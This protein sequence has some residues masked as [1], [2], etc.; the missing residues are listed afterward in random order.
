[1]MTVHTFLGIATIIM[2]IASLTVFT[3]KMK[4]L[5]GA[6]TKARS[7]NRIDRVGKR[8]FSLIMHVFGHKR[9]LKMRLSG[10]IHLFIFSGFVVLFLDI[11]ETIVKVIIPSFS[12]WPFLGAI[13]DIWVLIILIGIMMAFYNRRVVKP[14]RF[15][16]SNESDATF[17]LALITIIVV[18]I[19]I[20]TS[21]YMLIAED[22]FSVRPESGH[23][24]GALLAQLWI[25]IGWDTPTI[26]SIGYAVGYIMDIGTI[27]LFLA[28]LPGSK[29][30]H[31]LTSVP[32]V[33]TRDLD[34][35]VGL[36]TGTLT[37]YEDAKKHAEQGM[38]IYSFSDL[39]WKDTLDLYSCTECGRCQDVCPAYNAGSVL[40]PK[41]I[42]TDLRD[43]LK[44][45]LKDPAC[46]TAKS[47]LAGGVISKEALW[48]CTTCRACE[49][50]CP[51]FIEHVPKIVGLRAALVEEGTVETRAQ[52]TFKHWY[53]QGNA[54]AEKPSERPA[55]VKQADISFKDARKEA[56]DFLWFLGDV[57]S[58]DTD[59]G[60]LRSIQ[61]IGA[62][63]KEANLDVGLLYDG[64]ANSG[65]DALRMGEHGLFE[66]LAKE[67]LLT[68]QEATFERVVTSDPH[69]FNALLNDYPQFGFDKQVYHYTQ[70]LLNLVK[71]GTLE[72]KHSVN[73]RATYHDPC[74]L[75][76]WNG[77]F[78][79]PRELLQLCGAEIVEM[80]R[81]KMNSL[82][83][84][85]GGGRFFMNESGAEERP[86][87]SR[88]KEAVALEGVTHFVVTC[89]KDVVMYSAAAEELGLEEQIQVVDIAELLAEAV[90]LTSIPAQAG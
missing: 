61:S 9:L 34:R 38:A 45:T 76:R 80:P 59:P 40:N 16:G 72:I 71:D 47:P 5:I 65:N 31:V 63:F 11:M 68:I 70:L 41:L 22:V 44:E 55:V 83:C 29:H 57:A 52:E 7:V 54:Y 50:A 42:I 60:V 14:E 21:F 6:L 8:I 12:L 74:Y 4:P 28:Y 3:L 33:F 66:H 49:E 46:Q 35:P 85:A 37:G 1:M 73:A 36:P 53:E 13:V 19:V 64:E 82:C 2:L 39:T 20:H 79:Q 67:N 51:L 30:F 17:V 81:N 27:L 24:L 58:Y 84:G 43:A 75:G 26:A 86:S 15:K 87:E 48:A 32:S 62:L 10:I 56:V 69:S 88:I 18:G 78:D 23:F 90:G 25:A 77:I 89:P